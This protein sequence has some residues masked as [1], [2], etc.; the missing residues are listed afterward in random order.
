L[1]FIQ[2]GPLQYASEFFK[3]SPSYFDKDRI[4]YPESNSDCSFEIVELKTKL[5]SE[6]KF[7][8]KGNI[9]G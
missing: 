6:S 1:I 9:D 2:T 5:Y 3:Y 7:K 8:A 4:P